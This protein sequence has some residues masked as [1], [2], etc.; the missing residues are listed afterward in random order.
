MTI[1]L[2][3]AMGHSSDPSLGANALDACIVMGELIAMRE[4]LAAANQNNAFA[5]NVPTMNLGCIAGVQPYLRSCGATDRP[6][7]TAGYG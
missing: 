4:E 7:L 3:G 2:E 5:I 1:Q 6:A